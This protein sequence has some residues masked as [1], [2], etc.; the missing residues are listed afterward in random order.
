MTVQE[1]VNNEDWV[2]CFIFKTSVSLSFSLV[3]SWILNV[4]CMLKNNE[5]NWAFNIPCKLHSYWLHNDSQK[6]FFHKFYR[7]VTLVEQHQGYTYL[8][9]SFFAL[10][11]RSL[12]PNSWSLSS[13]CCLLPVILKD[14][15]RGYHCHCLCLRWW[16]LI[17][18]LILLV[19]QWSPQYSSPLLQ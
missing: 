1:I 2:V 17:G 8:S 13:V 10:V 7:G 11:V 15:G 6:P 19:R 4:K 18:R 14:S 9:F 12:F 3:I 16:Y 5:N